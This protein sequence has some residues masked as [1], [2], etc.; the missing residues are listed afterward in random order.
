MRGMDIVRC[1]NRSRS[2]RVSGCGLGLGHERTLLSGGWAL[3]KCTFGQPSVHFFWPL[4]HPCLQAAGLDG[5]ESFLFGLIFH[6]SYALISIPLASCVLLWLMCSCPGC[7]LFRVKRMFSLCSAFL[8]F[9]ILLLPFFFA[10]FCLKFRWLR[11]V[12]V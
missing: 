10:L 9:L 5:Q 4:F 11:V 2:N 6:F 3:E 12:I 8:F 7:P 1:W